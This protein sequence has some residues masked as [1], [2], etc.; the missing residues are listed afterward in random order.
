[1]KAGRL[2]NMAG[3]KTLHPDVALARRCASPT[4]PWLAACGRARPLTDGYLVSNMVH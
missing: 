2:V 4:R 1:M 3:L